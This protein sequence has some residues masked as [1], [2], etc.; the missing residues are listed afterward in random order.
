V[1]DRHDNTEDNIEELAVITQH[2]EIS[3]HTLISHSQSFINGWI[4][5]ADKEYEGEDA[6]RVTDVVGLT[7]WLVNVEK[8]ID[9]DILDVYHEHDHLARVEEEADHVMRLAE[10]NPF[11]LN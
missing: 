7:T 3:A 10:L 11:K 1:S 2:H 5:Q 6:L 8:V 9:V 4:N